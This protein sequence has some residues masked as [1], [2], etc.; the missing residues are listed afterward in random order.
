MGIVTFMDN[1]AL[2]GTVAV[3]SGTHQA[4][5]FTLS[6]PVGSNDI[7]ATYDGAGFA[8]SSTSLTE[9]VSPA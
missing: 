4:I 7:M 3:N 1:S 5:A 2:I 8:T 9:T 6:L